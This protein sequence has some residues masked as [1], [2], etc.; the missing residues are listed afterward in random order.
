M[1][2]KP[3]FPL[4]CPICVKLGKSYLNTMLFDISEFRENSR[5]WRPFLSC[6]CAWNFHACIGMFIRRVQKFSK[7][8]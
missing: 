5:R 8:L 3:H 4:H 6:G 1:K 7:T 2:L